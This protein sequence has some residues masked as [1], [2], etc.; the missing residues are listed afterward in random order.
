MSELAATAKRRVHPITPLV[1][2]S[3]YLPA[4][5]L[6]F[7]IGGGQAMFNRPLGVLGLFGMLVVVAVAALGYEFLAYR[8]LAFWFDEDGD[9]RVQS[10]V[11][12]HRERRLQLSRLQTVDVNRPLV[13]RFFGFAAL[14]VEVA[15]AGDS[16]ADLQYLAVDDAQALRS[17]ILARS[18]GLDSDAGEAP[19]QPLVVVPV[20]DLLVSLLLRA[21]TVLLVLGTV[22]IVVAT[23]LTSGWSGIFSVLLGGVPLAMV[24]TEF[25]QLYNFTV[26]DSPDGL[27]LRHGLLQTQA[28][29]IPPGRVCAVEFVEPLLWRRKGWVRLY[30]T[31]AGLSRDGDE[32][33]TESVMLPVAPREVAEDLFQRVMPG[34]QPA[35]VSTIGP[36]AQAR[37]R[38]WIQWPQ[39]A[40]GADASVAVLKRGRITRR[41]QVVD[42]ARVQSVRLTQGPWERA[43]GLA[44]VHLDLPPGRIRA[45]WLHF[46]LAQCQDL[47]STEIEHMRRA[48]A[49]DKSTRWM[50]G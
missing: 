47:L 46:G 30:V 42:H 25:T 34:V 32:A 19:E 14:R 4:L 11:I 23:V 20:G 49:S 12:F 22:L 33:G 28:R 37:R 41:M 21:V 36:V 27:R 6:A 3:T 17:E 26:A 10:G 5:I 8:R 18:A 2:V 7:I 38:S 39:L 48:R 1:R 45:S 40:A 31:V 29:T 9:L 44:S 16:R 43:L 24:F 13:A 50:R 35:A 15:G